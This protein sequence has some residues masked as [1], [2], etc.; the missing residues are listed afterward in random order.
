MVAVLHHL[1]G[2]LGHAVVAQIVET[3]FGVGAVGD[4]AE[5]LLAALF[6]VH[7]VL[8]AADGETEILVEMPHPGGVAAGEIVVHGDELD[9]LAGER[10]QIQRQRRHQRLAFARLHFGNLALM[11]NDT[12]YELHVERNH[13]PRKRMPADLL[14]RPDKLA[15][16]V[17]D[18][19]VRLRQNVVERLALGDAVLEFLRFA[20]KILIREV[21]SLIFLLYPVDF[22]DHGPEL[23]QFTIVFGSQYSL[24]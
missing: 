7:R 13:I 15:A 21:F 1:F 3:E 12:A 17:L 8:D 2:A 19:R 24:Q 16:G 14:R 4:V 22:P 5:I 23:F 20:R 11:Q 6:A 18:E 10:V 9:V